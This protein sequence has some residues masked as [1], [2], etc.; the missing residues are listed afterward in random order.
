MNV[1]DIGEFGLIARLRAKLPARGAG[2]II[3]PG[4]DAAVWRGESAYSIATTDTMVDGVHFLRDAVD[5]R[6]VGWKA[7]SVNV[8][9]VAAMGATPSYALVT[10]CLPP[11]T[12]VAWVDALYDGLVECAREYGVAIAGG[13]VV[14]S[15]VLTITIALA[16]EPALDADGAPLLMRR[17]AAT[18]GDLVAVSG[19]LG[20][21]AGGVRVLREGLAS[22]DAG[23]LVRR[24][25]RP[26]PRVDAGRAAALAGV[27]CAI[28][29]SDG[30]VQ[31]VGHICEESGCGAD[32]RIADLPVEPALARVFAD[33]ARVLAATGGEDYELVLV[34]PRETIGRASQAIG[35]PL[36]VV[37]EITRGQAGRVRLLDER[38]DEVAAPSAGWDH[39]ARAGTSA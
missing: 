7:L 2:V 29:V 25:M 15:P 34:A 32:L 30:L 6:D 13:D 35:A 33:G 38:G 4:D 21:S 27:R 3:G 36:T 11:D 31:D 39:F 10:L 26:R 9:D 23:A 19:P 28:D 18:P 12:P 22:D 37:G 8:S 1:S 16:G 24:H 14:S 17:S 5:A 20:G